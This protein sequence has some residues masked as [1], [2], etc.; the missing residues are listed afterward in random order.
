MACRPCMADKH[1]KKIKGKESQSETYK[2]LRAV[3]QILDPIEFE[4]LFDSLME[5][6]SSSEDSKDFGGYLKSNYVQNVKS[7]AY[8]HRRQSGLNK[9]MHLERMHC[10]IK[11]IYLKGKQGRRLDK[12]IGCLMSIIRD[13]LFL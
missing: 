2:K 8:C 5:E 11:Y 9:N 12:T 13:K 10:T 7:W 3:L 6:L 1:P 4:T